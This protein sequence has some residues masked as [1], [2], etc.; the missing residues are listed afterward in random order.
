M[1]KKSKYLFFQKYAGSVNS[2]C[3]N[4]GNITSFK[5][6]IFYKR[7]LFLD[8]TRKEKL[9]KKKKNVRKRESNKT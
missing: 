5:T 7:A 4:Q 9:K 6:W 1:L 2:L 3:L 8:K